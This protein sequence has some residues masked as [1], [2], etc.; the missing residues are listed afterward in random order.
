MI[1][2]M[3][4]NFRELQSH[5]CVFPEEIIRRRRHKGYVKVGYMKEKTI[6][7]GQNGT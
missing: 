3:K 1:S 6:L 4:K 7:D 5:I 2:A